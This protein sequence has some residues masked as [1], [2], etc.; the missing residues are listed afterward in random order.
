MDAPFTLPGHAVVG[1]LLLALAG[2]SLPGQVSPPDTFVDTYDVDDLRA[3]AESGEPFPLALL[4]GEVLVQVEPSFL[5]SERFRARRRSSFDER[6]VIPRRTPLFKG[7]IV[8]DPESVVRIGFGTTG[9]TAYVRRGDGVVT[10]IEPRDGLPARGKQSTPHLCLSP[11]AAAAGLTAAC[12]A[13]FDPLLGPPTTA[14]VTTPARQAADLEF[15][16]LELAVEADHAY[17]LEHGA[18]TV[19][20]IEQVLNIVEGIFESELGITFELTAIDVVDVGPDPYTASE[21]GLLLDQFQNH[22]NANNSGIPRD[23]AHLFTGRAMEQNVVGIAYLGQVC[24]LPWSYGLSRDLSSRSLMPL[25]VAHELGHNFGA[26]HDDPGTT[27]FIMN[28]S[29][30][31]ATQSE[32]STKS[33]TEIQLFLTQSNVTCLEVQTTEGGGDPGTGGT[34]PPSSPS[35]GGGPVDP[36]VVVAAAALAAWARR[37]SRRRVAR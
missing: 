30:S 26:G 8:G 12:G 5:R 7:R 2:P 24:T 23:V 17:Y 34:A 29:L 21:S 13:T 9:F 36:F 31:G 18:D 20:D 1:C 10:L 6:P 25:L 28:S 4:D 35:G 37:R 33:E 32:F 14:A 22:W 15:L 27:Q 11:A 3:A 16:V 19:A